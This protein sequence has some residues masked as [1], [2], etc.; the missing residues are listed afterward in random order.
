MK[1][2]EMQKEIVHFIGTKCEHGV[3]SSEIVKALGLNRHTL[4]KH[5]DILATKRILFFRKIGMAK[6]WFVNKNPLSVLYDDE[7]GPSVNS[8]FQEIISKTE[9]VVF[10]FDGNYNIIYMNPASEK[11]FGNCLGQKCHKAL[12]NLEKPCNSF[13]VVREFIHASKEDQ[14]IH[15]SERDGKTYRVKGFTLR[16]PDGS[17]T[18]MEIGVDITREQKLKDEVEELKKKLKLADA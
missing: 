4:A 11:I 7:V 8:I 15:F 5:L 2:S 10:A 1:P 6:L 13:C 12:K 16:N 9:N 3:L 14:K 17:L 18:A